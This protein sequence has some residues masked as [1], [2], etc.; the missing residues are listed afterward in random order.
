MLRTASTAHLVQVV[1]CEQQLPHVA[2]AGPELFRQVAIV[3]NSASIGQQLRYHLLNR[4]KRWL[5]LIDK[6]KPG[7][8]VTGHEQAG[9]SVATAAF[10]PPARPPAQLFVPIRN[11]QHL[12]IPLAPTVDDG[13][14]QSTISNTTGEPLELARYEFKI[15]EVLARRPGWVYSRDKLMDLVWEAPESS[16]DRTVDTHIKTI[17]AKLKLIKPEI[18]PIKTHRG[19][20]YSLRDSW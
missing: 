20:G 1:Q 6:R 8:C 10:Q 12:G 14:W 3:Q 4:S 16:T 7:V 18:D 17:R 15:L 19:L 2:I 9:T 11:D 5:D 13:D